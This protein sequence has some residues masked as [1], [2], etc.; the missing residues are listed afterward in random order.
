MDMTKHFYSLMMDW[1]NS[2]ASNKPAKKPALLWR[3]TSWF[4]PTN[5]D[6][7]IWLCC[8]LVFA[9]L[10]DPIITQQLVSGQ[11]EKSFGTTWIPLGMISGVLIGLATTWGWNKLD[12]RSTKI[13]LVGALV[14]CCAFAYS[15]FLTWGYLE[16]TSSLLMGPSKVFPLAISAGWP[17]FWAKFFG[18]TLLAA[19]VMFAIVRVARFGYGKFK[20]RTPISGQMTRAKFLIGFAGFMLVLGLIQNLFFPQ[21]FFAETNI[22][23]ARGSTTNKLISG[24]GVAI[25]SMF[26]FGATLAFA[27]GRFNV[28]K[29]IIL[30]GLL[31]FGLFSVAVSSVNYR[32]NP[33][34]SQIQVAT[35]FGII[36]SLWAATVANNSPAFAFSESYH[37]PQVTPA[38]KWPCVWSA[39]LVLFV[40]SSS[41][42]MYFVDPSIWI[43]SQ[44]WETALYSRRTARKSNSQ[45]RLGNTWGFFGFIDMTCNFKSEV[46]HDVFGDYQV[47][48]LA[49]ISIDGLTPEI[50]TDLLSNTQVVHLS[51]SKVTSRQ[52]SELLTGPNFVTLENVEVVDPD[53]SVE[54]I[55]AYLFISATGEYRV[56]S[57]L[58][59][60]KSA[61][62]ALIRISRGS[63]ESE[64]KPPPPSRDELDAIV[65]FSQRSTVSIEKQFVDQMVETNYSPKLSM[66][67]LV[68][69]NTSGEYY[70]PGRQVFPSLKNLIE[71]EDNRAL[72]E[73][74]F[75]NDISIAFQQDA[76]NESLFWDVAFVKGKYGRPKYTGAIATAQLT[77][78]ALF[79]NKAKR[80]GW[81]FGWNNSND[82]IT[83]LFLPLGE[84]PFQEASPLCSDFA[85]VETLS[86]EPDWLSALYLERGR[87]TAAYQQST[88][89][90]VLT[91]LS[92]LPNLK[93]LWLSKFAVVED[94][95][96]LGRMPKIE[97]LQIRFSDATAPFVDFNNAK[98]LKS[99]VY[100][101][102]PHKGVLDSL[103]QLLELGKLE[104]VTVVNLDDGTLGSPTAIKNLET[105]IPGFKIKVVH[106]KDFQSVPP[107]KFM[108]HAERFAAD[109]RERLNLKD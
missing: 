38:K 102:T 13:L 6:S 16:T 59:S 53:K 55:G 37:S 89:P 14:S 75:E 9:G 77:S 73:F 7:L 11:S 63:E 65:E 36:A 93:R 91:S 52:L 54:V 28:W 21:G 10:A 106:V 104:S 24:V 34:L 95:G 18:Y 1:M 72:R 68:V 20:A 49:S 78:S 87:P 3:L 39:L 12:V 79:Q 56:T 82:K 50:K 101:G 107:E 86:F 22:S 41:V 4:W 64:V 81:A 69:Q 42:L 27:S 108:K 23:F 25:G 109:A 84:E 96:V 105:Y 40:L 51:N 100:V 17:I 70:W 2:Q 88:V 26:Y 48:G 33:N 98:E 92:S 90:V 44:D 45:I 30:I 71:S 62:N 46:P 67:N 83:D 99:L 31:F 5:K 8:G 74:I 85:S 97:H 57:I 19:S 47:P 94:P 29:H 15:T 61:D 103:E 60:I 76:V 80:F 32:A 66:K 35:V 58:R 43:G